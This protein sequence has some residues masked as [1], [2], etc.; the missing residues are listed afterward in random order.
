MKV[1]HTLLTVTPPALVSRLTDLARAHSSPSDPAHD[2]LHV[3]RVVTNAIT[4]AR[5]HDAD[6]TV[7]H[8]SALLHEL[9]NLPKNH[10]DSPRSGEL[11]A[12]E[13]RRIL[14]AENLDPST[15]DSVTYAIAVHPFSLGVTPTTVEARVLQDADRL[16]ALGAI[17]I[18]RCFATCTSMSVPFYHPDDPLCVHRAPNDKLWGVDHFY[19]KLLTLASSMHTETA[20]AIA[21]DRTDFMKDFLS[22]LGHEALGD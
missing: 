9:V 15:I 16:D 5:A 8:L 22:R 4:L 18:A 10:Q 21:R 6:E 13:A 17:G 3:S 12:L 20:R 2:F 7:C 14:T 19:K 11:C 1:S